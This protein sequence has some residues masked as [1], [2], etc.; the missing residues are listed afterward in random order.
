MSYT[1]PPPQMSGMLAATPRDS[2]IASMNQKNDILTSLMKNVGGSKRSGSHKYKCS[3]THR[4]GHKHSCSHK[5]KC[6]HKHKCSHKHSCKRSRRRGSKRSSSKRSGIKRSGSKRSSKRGGAGVVVAQPPGLNLVTDPSAGTSQ[7]IANQI[8]TNATQINQSGANAAL[9]SKVVLAPI[10]P[11][12][13]RGGKKS[14]K[15]RKS[16]K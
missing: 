6:G 2:A 10:P 8:T 1:V 11:P 16:R 13:V 14:K 5:H 12:P 9:D 4:C 3:H 15:S 7:S